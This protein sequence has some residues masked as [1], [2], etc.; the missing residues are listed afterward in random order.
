MAN[1]ETAYA[2]RNC[3]DYMLASEE[4][5]PTGGW[6][7]SAMFNA[8]AKN[9]NISEQKLGKAVCNG[10]RE[11]Y[12][13][14]DSSY[15]A[16]SLIDLS[17]IDA[18]RNIFNDALGMLNNKKIEINDVRNVADSAQ[19]SCRCGTNS[20]YTGYSNLIDMV[21]FSRYYGNLLGNNDFS[22][23]VSSCIAYSTATNNEEGHD[24]L[25]FY[26]PLNYR[27]ETFKEYYERI[28]PVPSYKSYLKRVYQ[29]IPDNTVKLKKVSVTKDGAMR[30]DVTDDSLPYILGKQYM[31]YEILEY[32]DEDTKKPSERIK[33]FR[34]FGTDN[35]IEERND[36]R[37]Y[38]SNFRG[39]TLTLNGVELFYDFVGKNHDSYIF[40][41]PVCVNGKPSY[42]R[43][44]F[45]FDESKFNNGHYEII[46]L[47]NGIDPNIGMLDK[48]FQPLKPDDDVEAYVIERGSNATDDSDDSQKVPKSDDGYKI[49]EEPL[50]GKYYLYIGEYNDEEIALEKILF[51]VDCDFVNANLKQ[52]VNLYRMDCEE[53]IELVMGDADKMFPDGSI[54]GY[55]SG[56]GKNE[57]QYIWRMQEFDGKLYVGTFDTSSL[58]ETIG[59]FTNGDLIHMTPEEWKRQIKYLIDFLSSIQPEPSTGDSQPV[60]DS[61]KITAYV[62]KNTKNQ[63]LAL[64]NSLEEIED[65]IDKEISVN[66]YEEY[67]KALD[68]F[69]N[70][71]DRLS[72]YIKSKFKK[73]LSKETLNKMKSIITCSAY[74]A[75]AERGFDLYTIDKNMNVEIVT[76]NGF[77]DPYNHGRRVFAVN[78][79]GL[80]L[81][82][83]NPFYG[84]QVWNVKNVKTLPTTPTDTSTVPSSTEATDASAVSTVTEPT[85]ESTEPTPAKPT[86]SAPYLANKSVKKAAGSTYRIVVR[87]AGGKKITYS[88]NNKKILKVSSKGKVT[89]LKKGSGTVTVKAGSK[90]LTFKGIVTSNPK[91]IYK[92]KTVKASKTYKVKKGN[93]LTVKIKGKASALKNKYS[94]T[95]IAKIKG[96]AKSSKIKIV[97]LK[98]GKT[99][100]KITVNLT[101]VLKIKVK[102]KYFF[103]NSVY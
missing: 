90:K 8:L 56:F 51:N 22:D 39:V 74:L 69:K 95:K 3:A 93:T 52:S 103:R 54:T 64:A 47:W 80:I 100:L 82:T 60:T 38:I 96:K 5:E 9:K 97:G 44:A 27:D 75:K 58:L 86:T 55:G 11:K 65:N 7:Y 20:A 17:R 77:G 101:K 84:T 62:G 68:N 71:S 57:N 61:N 37:T 35:D 70:L 23:I 59:Q 45:V 15:A 66:V 63:A 34:M 42:L 26:Y 41:A 76:T 16:L 28:C 94:S 50:K 92:N 13:D 67:K 29:N 1:F 25:S 87:N 91:L 85:T 98:K 73:V 30:V 88:S 2:L 6:D 31:L 32:S 36:G 14:S 33:L 19:H 49:T 46:G 81:G 53:N 40:E 21:D 72:S 83:A 48:G 43:F 18:V 10:F 4:I 12:T 102:V 78:N 79:S 99:T 24:G 89:F